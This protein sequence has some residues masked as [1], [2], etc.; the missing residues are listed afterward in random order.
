[1]VD[2]YRVGFCFPALRGAS[3]QILTGEHSSR[4]T[5]TQMVNV[6]VHRPN[7]AANT[8]CGA[9]DRPIAGALEDTCVNS[10]SSGRNRPILERSRP[11][12]CNVGQFCNFGQACAILA[13]RVRIQSNFGPT[14][15]NFVRFRPML[16]ISVDVWRIRKTAAISPNFGRLRPSLRDLGQ[17][18][19]VLANLPC[20][21]VGYI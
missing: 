2:S 20:L 7:F 4:C 15:A 18:R 17:F 11:I 1:M 8:D 6:S 10:A 13:F 12:L 3:T 21:G 9:V 19:P 14:S 16:S 5:A